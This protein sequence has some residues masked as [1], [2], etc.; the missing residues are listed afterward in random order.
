MV[1]EIETYLS[2]CARV[3]YAL[4]PVVAVAV[5]GALIRR[6]ASTFEAR[7]GCQ[8]I[9]IFARRKPAKLSINLLKQINLQLEVYFQKF[10]IF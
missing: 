1:I 8:A 4:F 7:I 3:L 2:I 9:R 6:T 10:T 5:D